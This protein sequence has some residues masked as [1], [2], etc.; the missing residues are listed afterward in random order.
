[1]AFS[2]FHTD[3]GVVHVN[4]EDRINFG[5]VHEW[6]MVVGDLNDHETGF[7]AYRNVGL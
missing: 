5:T 1:M 4:L 7:Y 6:Y 2:V 3:E